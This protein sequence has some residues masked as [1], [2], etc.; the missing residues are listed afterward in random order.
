[1]KKAIY[2][3]TLS[4][5]LI[6]AGCGKTDNH[7][8]NDAEHD[9]DHADE[10]EVEMTPEQMRVAGVQ[11]GEI[12]YKN[13]GRRLRLSGVIAVAP[14]NMHTIGTP[15]GGYVR[16]I[17]LVPGMKVSKGEVLAV[18]EDPQYVQLQQ[19]YLTAKAHIGYLESD[20]AR[21]RDLNEGQ[22]GNMKMLEKARADL[23]AEQASLAALAEK[24]RL[25]GMNPS[26][27][28]PGKLTSRINIVAPASGYVSRVMANPGKYVGAAD[29]IAEIMSMEELYLTLTVYEK[30]LNLI[31]PGQLVEA[32]TADKPNEKYTARVK[33]VSKALDASRSAS[34]QCV[35]EKASSL[36]G[37]GTYMNALVVTERHEAPALPAAAVVTH[38]GEQFAFVQQKPNIFKMVKISSGGCEDNFCAINDSTA[39]SL[40]GRKIVIGG[41]YD[42]LMKKENI[43]D[44]HAH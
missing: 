41:A 18:L 16:S 44:G 42:M 22:A 12:S 11:L 9:H 15:M 32:Y 23:A 25:I 8:G 30:D 20:F 5:A 1:M 39:G 37:P 36:P 7:T 13:I 43:D 33:V 3:L 27:V 40:K 28:S 26:S 6:A 19:D 35:F 29:P 21:Q 2:I 38:L 10:T 24:L 17:K 31:Q 34:V 14:D 4:A